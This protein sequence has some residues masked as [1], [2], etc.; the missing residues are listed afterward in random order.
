MGPWSVSETKAAIFVGC[1]ILLWVTNFLHH[2]P[3]TMV[4]LGIGLAATLPYV[5]VLEPDDVR[6]LNYMPVFFVAEG[7]S[8][9]NVLETTKGLGVLTSGVFH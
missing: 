2:I 4:A 6:R 3:P 9:G 7:V 8:M 1:A 5:G